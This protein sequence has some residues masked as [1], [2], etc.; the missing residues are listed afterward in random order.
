MALITLISH[1]IPT[2]S[3]LKNHFLFIRDSTFFHT[4]THTHTHTDTFMD[5]INL[6][7]DKIDKAYKFFKRCV[8]SLLSDFLRKSHKTTDHAEFVHTHTHTHTHTH[9]Y[10]YTYVHTYIHTYIHTY[11]RTY[12]HTYVRTYIHTRT[13]MHT[14][15]P[16]IL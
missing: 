5:H 6:R 16:Y 1:Y 2:D 7:S 9:I 4:H 3:T 14:Y 13:Y 15:F 8:K 11:V 12:M 10:I